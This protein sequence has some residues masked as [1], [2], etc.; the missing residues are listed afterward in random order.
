[1]S[2]HSIKILISTLLMLSGFGAMA[3]TGTGSM[4]VDNSTVNIAAGT[5]EQRFS[6]ESYFGPEANWTIDGTL[7]IWSKKIWIAPGAVF[8]GLGKIVIYNPGANP[9]YPGMASGQTKIDGNNGNFINLII[10]HRN[11]ENILLADVSDP[12]Y[13]T[14]N[15]TGALSAELNIGGTLDLAA[16]RAD[17]ILN[18]HNLAFNSSGKIENYSKSRMVVTG[19]SINGHMIKDYAGSDGFVFPVGIEEGD[20]TPATLSP[21]SVGKLFVSVQD[22]AGANKAIKNPALGMD[23]VWHIY[24]S[25]SLTANMILQHNSNTNGSLFKDANAAI[26]R[27]L[28]GEKWDILK[29]TN[30][31]VGVHTRNNVALATDMAANGGYFTKL[32]VSGATL[33][34]PNLYTPN[35]DGTNDTFE[36][37][38]LELFE[39]NDLIIVNRWG[40]EV[41]KATGYQN[42]WTGEGLNEGTYFYVLRVKEL[43]GAEWQVF[44]GYITLIRAFKK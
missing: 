3:Q 37:R 32:N 33:F 42:N 29:G 13:K 20:Y 4:T 6:E 9:F 25:P 24:G 36:I 1:M 22:Y 5:T 12:G 10:E 21:G 26:A 43:A 35:G 11:E 16:D 27:Y 40:N 28:S 7:E 14:A 44:K 23:R 19:N 15:P 18:G 41:Y 17:I 30:P 2:S 8:K 34:I 38:G 39:E 31:G